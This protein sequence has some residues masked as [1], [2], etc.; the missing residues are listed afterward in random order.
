MFKKIILIASAFLLSFSVHAARFNAGEDY[1]ILN[2]PRSENPN[3][4]EFFSFIVHFAI[5]AKI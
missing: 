5:A 3:V 1:Q 2:T 4:A